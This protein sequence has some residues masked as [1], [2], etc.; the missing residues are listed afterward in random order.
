M[1]L[2]YHARIDVRSKYLTT[3]ECFIRLQSVKYA[4]STCEYHL[5]QILQYFEG[6]RMNVTNWCYI[7]II[8]LDFSYLN[9]IIYPI[10][11]VIFIVMSIYSLLLY[12]NNDEIF[13]QDFEAKAS[14][15]LENLKETFTVT[16]FLMCYPTRVH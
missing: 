1:L 9:L 12:Y 13:L 8:T 16:Y 2:P 5:M 14:E 15:L 3:P 10:G 7:H 4:T 11:L 6:K